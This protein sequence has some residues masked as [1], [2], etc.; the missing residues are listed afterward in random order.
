[1]GLPDNSEPRHPL[2]IFPFCHRDPRLSENGSQEILPDVAS[3]GIRNPH[4]EMLFGHELVFPSR[5]RTTKPQL[6]KAANQL[7]ARC[8]P[9]ARYQATS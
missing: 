9:K 1:M 5:I 7:C 4:T 2:K 6:A 8:W 3:M